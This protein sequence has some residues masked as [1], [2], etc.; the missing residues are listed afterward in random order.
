MTM[1]KLLHIH[2]Q[3]NKKQMFGI[4]KQLTDLLLFL[5]V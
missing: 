5:S 4:T 2:E 3:H 1:M